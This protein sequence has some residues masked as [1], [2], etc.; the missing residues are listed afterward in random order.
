MGK[1]EVFG[2]EAITEEMTEYLEKLPPKDHKGRYVWAV[3]AN[4]KGDPLLN[5]PLV[6]LIPLD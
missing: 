6:R 4:D 2:I 5:L 1:E 3:Q